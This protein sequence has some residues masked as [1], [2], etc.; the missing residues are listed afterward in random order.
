[1]KKEDLPKL[2]DRQLIRAYG[3]ALYHRST[4]EGLKDMHNRLDSHVKLYEEEMN[5]RNIPLTAKE[6]DYES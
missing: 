5:S 4:A 6:D 1:M 2:N 3:F